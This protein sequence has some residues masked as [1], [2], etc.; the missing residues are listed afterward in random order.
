MKK[1]IGDKTGICIYLLSP[2]KQ[3]FSDNTV[4]Q[5]KWYFNNQALDHQ[6]NLIPNESTTTSKG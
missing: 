6:L 1:A 3:I 5:T 4:Q 2:A